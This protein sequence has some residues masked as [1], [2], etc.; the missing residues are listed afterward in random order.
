MGHTRDHIV[1]FPTGAA[2]QHDG[3]EVP[4]PWQ[5]TDG[6]PCCS[7][8]VEDGYLW[9]LRSQGPV[10]GRPL[11]TRN[12]EGPHNAKPLTEPKRVVVEIIIIICSRDDW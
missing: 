7:S 2:G 6:V 4:A 12:Q 1:V 9:A 5:I 11:A 8:T 3:G 10:S